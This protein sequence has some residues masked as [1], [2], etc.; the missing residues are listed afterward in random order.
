MPASTSNAEKILARLKGLAPHLQP[1]E[2][3]IET[4]PAIWDNGQDANSTLCD[5]VITNQRVIGFYFRSFPREKLF[6]DA[7]ALADIKNV[8]LRQ[9]SH[10]PVF[11][12]ILISAGTRKVYI[13]A[14]RKKIAA[15][16][17]ALRAAI[18]QY[19]SIDRASSP[20]EIEVSNTQSNQTS[21]LQQEQAQQQTIYGRQDIKQP[22]EAS[23]LAI[24]LLFVGGI[25][26]EIVG[27]I[28][29][30]T[31]H[32]AQIGL[33]LCFAGFIAVGTSIWLRRKQR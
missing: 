8:T 29:W 21:I 2:E 10:E 32:D 1:G 9:K 19:G 31:T 20:E 23:V 13:R 27:V 11:R 3:P 7:S 25:V 17:T 24:L 5:V 33:P 12:E 18:D 28:L 30:S 26:L 4:F 22:F 16:Y 6:L 15:L 14:P